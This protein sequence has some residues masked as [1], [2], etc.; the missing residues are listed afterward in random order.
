MV[1]GG[2]VSSWACINFSR[3]VQD[4]A[5]RI[6]CHELAQMCQVSGMV[7]VNQIELQYSYL[8]VTLGFVCVICPSYSVL[9][10]LCT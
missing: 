5:A 6:F 9:L 2:R 7:R 1:N 3:N 4:N 10:G 8:F